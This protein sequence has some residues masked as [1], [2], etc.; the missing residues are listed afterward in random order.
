MALLV[1][2]AL[3]FTAAASAWISVPVPRHCGAAAR[4]CATA[5]DDDSPLAPG[6]SLLFSS[7]VLRVPLNDHLPSGT[8]DALEND[9]LHSWSDHLEEQSQLSSSSK[10]GRRLST[11][12]QRM[13]A[14]TGQELNEEFFYY[15]RAHYGDMEHASVPH[16][17]KRAWMAGAAGQA[18]LAAVTAASASYLAQI[19]RLAGIDPEQDRL[20]SFYTDA[21]DA[22]HMHAWASV[23]QGGSTHPRHVHAGSVVSAVLYV[24]VPEDAGNICFFDP[25]GSIPPFERE[26]CHSPRSGDLLLFPPWLAH[27]VAATPPPSVEGDEEEALHARISASFNYVDVTDALQQGGP[28]GWG[29][30]TAG[31]EV[32][33]LDGWSP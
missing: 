8:L 9:V 17:N 18:V 26:V 14:S 10:G 33:T 23:H 30:A 1:T 12:G 32:A 15:Q 4:M 5:D 29:E 20:Y 6:L 16:T 31:L 7:P 19:A 2:T 3:T 28:S 21:L 11:D 27:A 22:D 24:A 13:R 25:R